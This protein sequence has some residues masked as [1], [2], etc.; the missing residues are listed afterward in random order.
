MIG[1][2]VV[3][4]PE[5]PLQEKPP[6]CIHDTGVITGSPVLCDFIQSSVHAKGRAIGPV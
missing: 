4:K 3:F 5:S 2:K 1:G 6:A